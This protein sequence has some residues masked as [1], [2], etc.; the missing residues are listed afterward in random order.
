MRKYIL[1][2]LVFYCCFLFS[3]ALAQN[4][5]LISGQPT[6]SGNPTGYGSFA[7]PSINGFVMGIANVNSDD[8]PDLFLQSD[9]WNPGTYVYFFD[10]YNGENLPV[11]SEARKV[12]IPFDTE[13]RNRAIILENS[14]KEI[15]GFWGFGDELKVAEFHKESLSYSKL[16][17]IKIKA[18]PI[19]FDNFGVIQLSNSSYLFLFSIPDNIY[20]R[21]PGRGPNVITY[22]PEGFWQR[23]IS[24]SGIYGAFVSSLQQTEI[25]AKQLTTRTETYYSIEGYSLYEANSQQFLICGTRLGNIHSYK[26]DAENES[27][28]SADYVVDHNDIILRNPSVH[29]SLAFFNDHSNR[30][31]IVSSEGGIYYYKTEGIFNS[32]NKIVFADPSHLLQS[33]PE[34]YGGSLVVPNL[35]DWDGDEDLDIISGTSQGFIFLFENVGNNTSPKFVTAQKLK[36][37][38]YNIHIQPGYNQDIQGPG[39][40]RWGYSCP[41]VFDW[42]GNGLPDILTGDSRGKFNVYINSGSKKAPYLEPEHPL[43]VN[44]MDMHGTWRVRPGVGK[45]G[46]KMAYICLDADDEFHLYW[47]LDRYNLMD[48][49]KLTIGDSMNIKANFLN[50]GATGRAKILIVDWDEDGIKD[51]LVGT[52]R[53]GSIPEPVN[54][55]PYYLPKNGASVIFLKNSG[56]EENPIFEYPAIVKFK[57]DPI[58]LGQHACAPTV[59]KI[60]PGNTENLIVGDETGR[61]IF[62]ERKDL[63]Y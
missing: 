16:R 5:T 42:T 27:L 31:L 47:Q 55:L 40:S 53:H 13:I 26:I 54:G 10:K 50:A 9:R 59:G 3:Y 24:K 37:G 33:D 20:K 45:L 2:S 29:G 44:G 8:K 51:L 12:K 32:D 28:H 60:G 48:G 1:I 25:H 43:F 14:D 21:Y 63:T 7:L 39:E 18:L 15:F 49:K 38:G 11:F 22:G 4:N 34:L 46:N 58:L 56:S 57:G 35:V 36:A 41:I 61:F 17:S 19:K 62:F 6:K 23:P 30:G 52:P